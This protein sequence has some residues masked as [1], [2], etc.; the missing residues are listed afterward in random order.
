MNTIRELKAKEKYDNILKRKNKE[1]NIY[2][3]KNSTL[4]IEKMN[5]IKAVERKNKEIERLNKRI[6]DLNII[7]EEH[8]TLN[9]MIRKELQQKENIIN[10]LEK[11]LEQEYAVVKAN[12]IQEPNNP[13]W[14]IK[15]NERKNTLDKLQELK[16][17]EKE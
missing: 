8:K 2:K 17:S 3:S 7:N 13:E 16:G 9:G 11:W 1:K 12:S 15:W 5:L 10:K 6:E 4:R 14:Y